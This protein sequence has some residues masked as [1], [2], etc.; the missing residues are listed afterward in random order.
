MRSLKSH[1]NDIANFLHLH[2]TL[3]VWIF[4]RIHHLRTKNFDHFYAYYFWCIPVRPVTIQGS[5]HPK[6]KHPKR[7]II[8][9]STK[10]HNMIQLWL[11]CNCTGVIVL[12]LLLLC[13]W[14]QIKPLL[15]WI[16][17]E[18]KCFEWQNVPSHF[19]LF[20]DRHV[21]RTINYISFL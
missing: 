20:N 7:M 2:I 10:L 8:S 21:G 3:V 12:K 16:S 9:N 19:W 4:L 1:S 18:K 17:D 6:E 13:I 14:G 5:V 11:M 15:L